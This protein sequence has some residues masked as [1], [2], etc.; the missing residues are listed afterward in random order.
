MGGEEGE[1]GGGGLHLLRIRLLIHFDPCVTVRRERLFQ[2]PLRQGTLSASR[3]CYMKHC[4]R[5]PTAVAL[6][7]SR[8][9]SYGTWHSR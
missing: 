6:R 7:R 1:G 4:L 5:V 8:P 2:D 9:T 3:S